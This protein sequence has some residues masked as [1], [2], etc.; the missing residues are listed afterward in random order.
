MMRLYVT[1]R[2]VTTELQATYG[3]AWRTLAS[4]ARKAGASAWVFQ[5]SNEAGRFMEFIEIRPDADSDLINSVVTPLRAAL[6]NVAPSEE[7]N[8]WEEWSDR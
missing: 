7:T 6:D 5:D 2:R 3:D 1:T 8:M 4:A